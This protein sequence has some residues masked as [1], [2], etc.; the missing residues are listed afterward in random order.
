LAT[1]LFFFFLKK[2]L[3]IFTNCRDILNYSTFFFFF[4]LL[5]FLKKIMYSL[6][7]TLARRSPGSISNGARTFTAAAAANATSSE[8]KDSSVPKVN[9]VSLNSFNSNHAL[10]DRVRPDFPAAAVDA[11]VTDLM[12]LNPHDPAVTTRVV[13]VGSGTGKFTKALVA[14]GFAERGQLEAVEPSAGMNASFRKNFPQGPPVHEASVYDLGKVI[15]DE[16]ADGILIAQAFH[17][18]GNV[19]ALRA[20][21]KAL[22]PGAKLGLIWNYEDLDGLPA[23]NWQRQT[24][25]YV[26]QFDKDVPQYKDLDWISAFTDPANHYFAY[27]Y[28]ERFITHTVVIPRAMVW[29]YWA[30]RSYITA[31]PQSKQ[32][33]IRKKIEAIVFSDDIPATDLT[34]NGD[35]IARRGTHIVAALKK[36]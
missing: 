30:S 34:E 25:E 20:L 10:Y 27:P 2:N 7:R 16:S 11:L 13:E 15:A 9:Q 19:A 6:L 12:H 4:L 14:R 22:K 26:W 8:G 35:L 1:I 32:D 23:S 17:W 3:S 18:F 5:S 21:A 33:E 31:L 24:T 29:P 36:E 28:E